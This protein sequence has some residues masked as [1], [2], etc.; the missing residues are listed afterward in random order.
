MK[1]SRFSLL[2]LIISA[3]ASEAQ[4]LYRVADFFTNPIEYRTPFAFLPFEIKL[5]PQ[6]L[7]VG[8]YPLKFDS[9]ESQFS[10]YENIFSRMTPNFEIEF[11][12]FNWLVYLIPQNFVDLPTGFGLRYCDALVHLKPPSNWTTINPVTQE[13]LMLAPR[14]WEYNLNQSA[15][16]QW[17]PQ[18]YGYFTFAYGRIYATAYLTD[19]RKRLLSQEGHSYSFCLGAKYLGSIG[20]R[21][22]EGFGVE[23]KYTFARLKPCKDPLNLSP[24]TSLNLNS[25]GLNLTFAL[26]VGGSPTQADDGKKL[27]SQGDYLA[28]KA[29]FE[30]FL[31]QYPHH[32]RRFKAQGMIAECQKRIPFQEIVLAEELIAAR[33][34]ARAVEHLHA[35]WETTNM[36]L[37]MRVEKNYQLLT[38]WF[39]DTMDSLLTANLI[40]QAVALVTNF[41]TFKIPNTTPIIERY[42]SEIWF[43]RGA[44]FTSYGLWEKAID[45]FD[46]AINKYPPIRERVSPWLLKIAQGYIN[47]ANKAVDKASIALALESLRQ[48]TLIRPEIAVITKPYITTLEQGLSYLKQE[49]GKAQLRATIERVFNPPQ[50]EKLPTTGMSTESVRQL[51]GEPLYRNVISDESQ[52]DYELWI[53]PYAHDADCYLYFLNGKLYKMEIMPLPGTTTEE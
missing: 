21:L 49:A 38:D 3:R 22:K 2:L 8:S 7:G 34:Y 17:S 51:W 46:K 36:G 25:I 4:I 39:Q 47:D 33:D 30:E 44:V 19:R 48:A 29:N 50:P 20:Y 12:K 10:S 52:R 11:A 40:E 53:Y 6:I 42:W 26:N 5:G 37:R 27:Y 23:L 32:P 15:L 9:T 13:K 18:W 16:F 31:R 43:H 28:A 24:I 35:A 41:E 45:A 14:L 1:W